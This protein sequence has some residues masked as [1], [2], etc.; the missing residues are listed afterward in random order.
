MKHKKFV[1][2]TVTMA[3]AVSCIFAGCQKGEGSQNEP[4][5]TEK[6]Y[7]KDYVEMWWDFSNESRVV[8]A[9]AIYDFNKLYKEQYPKALIEANSPIVPAGS[10][11]ITL[12]I[13]NLAGNIAPDIV[14]VDSVY[15]PNL[16][17]NGQLQ[18]LKDYNVEELKDKYFPNAWDG[19]VFQKEGTQH[20]YGIPWVINSGAV[21]M[22]NKALLQEAN[23]S[24]APKTYEEMIN[25]G[26]AIKALNKNDTY[27]F[28]FPFAADSMNYETFSFCFWLWRL[29]GDV[30]DEAYTKATF[31]SHEGV[32]ALQMIISMVSTYG[33]APSDDR[34]LQIGSGNIGFTEYYSGYVTNFMNNESASETYGVSLLPTLKEG[35]PN[36]S[37]LGVNTFALVNNHVKENDQLAYDFM[38]F[39]CT[40]P[41]Y[42]DDFNKLYSGESSSLLEGN[43]DEKYQRDDWQVVLKQMDESKLRPKVPY[44]KNIEESIAFAIDE[45]LSNGTPP[46]ETL[47]AA[48]E[49]V[50]RIIEQYNTIGTVP[51]WTE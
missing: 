27:G 44:W 26:N 3:I 9:Q 43:Q 12:L 17:L 32:Q 47:N 29:G 37:G 10:N 41:I 8:P 34:Q 35:I 51:Q 1:V 7:G 22:Y 33:I 20:I 46:Q 38:K 14:R 25:A 40:E 18:D 4:K 5:A 39:L 45:S 13:N 21:M 15:L 24:E 42:Q 19:V 49:K 36:Y 48:A 50:N 6:P 28:T 31:N 16:G 30:L 2:L 23:I 11:L